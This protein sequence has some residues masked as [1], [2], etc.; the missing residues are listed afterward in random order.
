M[1]NYT[2]GEIARLCCVSVRTV[3]YYDTRGILTPTQLSEGGRRLYSEADLSKMKI[4]CF[5][6]TL[7]M[8]LDSIARLMDESNSDEVIKLILEE[9]RKQLQDDIAAKKERLDRLKETEKLLSGASHLSVESIESVA[10]IMENKKQMRRLRTM[11]I[12]SAIPLELAEIGTVLLWITQKIA[13]PFFLYTV[14]L[15]PY[16][17]WISL[18]YFKRVAYLCP[19]CHEIFVPGLRHAF[20]AAHTPTTRKLTCP[21]CAYRGYCIETYRKENRNGTVD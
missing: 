2:T 20:F 14:V 19:G 13:W 15:I 11:M 7:D 9:Q 12:L 17:V 1:P 16:A 18:F 8:P 10:Q 4:I 6:R 3:Q 21:H 5:L